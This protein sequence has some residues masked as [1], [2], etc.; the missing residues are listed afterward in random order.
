MEYKECKRCLFNSDIDE[1]III[2]EDG[3][4]NHCQSYDNKKKYLRNLSIESNEVKQ[5]VK[6]IKERNRNS[7]YD[8]I[9][10]LSGGIDSSYSAYLLV[11]MGLNPIAVH[12]D[13]GWNSELAVMN[14]KNLVQKLNIDLL[15][16]VV[17]WQEFKDLQLSYLKASV[18]DIEAIT[19]QAIS[20]TLIKVAKKLK[21]KTIISGANHRTEGTLP[22]GWTYIKSD[23]R[24][25][26]DIHKKF[27][28][29][30]LKTYPIVG[31]FKRYFIQRFKLIETID[32]L[33]LIKY[34]KEEA[35]YILEKEM[36]WRDYG[37]KHYES[38]FTRFYQAYILPV[39]FKIDKRYSHYSTLIC[40]G[41]I[42]KEEAKKKLN[43]P[44]CDPELLQKDKLYVCKKLELS[45]KEFDELMLL[46]PKSHLEYKNIYQILRFMKIFK[47]SL[48]KM[49]RNKF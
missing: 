22:D 2:N 16:Y 8:C 35:K 12:F 30:K 25:I 48:K 39:K 41:Q 49:F 14:I 27:G 31:Y 21:I 40:A 33:D 46:K 45:I 32:I 11:K 7:K 20:A 19:D 29:K 15:T 47:I 36:G 42:T 1:N 26:R 17:D 24:N 44:I 28:K 5:I 3:I 18:V 37:G 13:N 4:C 9:I 6:Y 23:D 10:G 43:E 38:I 34:E